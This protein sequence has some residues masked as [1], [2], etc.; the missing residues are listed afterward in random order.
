MVRLIALYLKELFDLNPGSLILAFRRFL[1]GVCCTLGDTHQLGCS[2]DEIRLQ[3][4]QFNGNRVGS[5]NDCSAVLFTRQSTA[6]SHTGK[7]GIRDSAYP[8]TC[9]DN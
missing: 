4:T 8:F 9:T 7:E 6:F 1:E 2:C 5:R 3:T